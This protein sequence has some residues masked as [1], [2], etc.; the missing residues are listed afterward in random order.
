MDRF[1]DAIVGSASAKIARHRLIDLLVRRS[2]RFRQESHGGHDLAGLAVATLRHLLGDPGLLHGMKATDRQPFNCRDALTPGLR[3]RR[4][5]RAHRRA[6]E[7]DRAGATE[8][9]A[10]TELCPR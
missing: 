8:P 7:V 4:R 6:I 1:A 5:A 10:A 2:R 9:D 3:D